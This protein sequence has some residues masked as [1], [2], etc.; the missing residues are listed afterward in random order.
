M[1]LNN[2]TLTTLIVLFIVTV[3]ACTKDNIAFKKSSAIAFKANELIVSV[4]DKFNYADTIFYLKS[5]STDYIVKPLKTLSGTFGAY[6]TGLLHINTTTGA[7]NVTKSETGLKYEVWFIA[8]GSTDTCKR[9]IT[10]SGVDFT[11]SVYSL[12]KTSVVA[13]PIY[14]A[15]KTLAMDCTNGC[16]FDDG[17]SAAALGIAINKTSG[18]IDLKKTVQNGAFGKTPVDGSFVDFILNYRISDR[19]SNAL[20]KMALRLYYY[21]S[22]AKVPAKLIEELEAKKGQVI[23]DDTHV[24]DNGGGNFSASAVTSSL[25]TATQGKTTKCR[26]P[27]IIVTAQ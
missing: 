18:K 15:N 13:K 8:T 25:T 11:D 5:S 27:Y 17:G 9:F 14:N 21:T 22:R 10:I 16:V 1:K 20:N 24:D 3:L 23:S 4:C 19:S 12:Q 2:L 7:I 26:P 6:P